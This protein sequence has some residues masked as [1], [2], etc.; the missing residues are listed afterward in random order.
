MKDFNSIISQSDL[1]VRVHPDVL[2]NLN[3]KFELRPYQEE[4]LARFGFYVSEV[5]SKNHPTQLLFHMATGSG[6]TL[7]MAAC[8]LELY[9][10]GYRRFLFFVNSTAIIEKTRDNFLNPSSSK[11]LFHSEIRCDGKRFEV[12]EV[13]NFEGGNEEGLQIVFTTVQGLHTN[14]NSPKENSLTF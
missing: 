13:E 4:A 3:P 14:L 8:I 9:R 5:S 11:Y 12:L 2:R 1:E 7:V 6:K 10:K